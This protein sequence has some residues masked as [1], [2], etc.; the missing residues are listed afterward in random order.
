MG[1]P[2][3]GATITGVEDLSTQELKTVAAGAA[4]KD[5]AIAAELLAREMASVG[6]GGKPSTSPAGASAAAVAAVDSKGLKK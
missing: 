4:D 1:R 2:R 3:A 5:G 6:L